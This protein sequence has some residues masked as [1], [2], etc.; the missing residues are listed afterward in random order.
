MSPERAGAKIVT[1]A[2]AVARVARWRAAGEAVVLANGVFDLLH[3]GHA[4]YL[5]AGSALSSATQ[6]AKHTKTPKRFI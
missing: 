1:R 2:E 6:S 5:A 3:V 4:R